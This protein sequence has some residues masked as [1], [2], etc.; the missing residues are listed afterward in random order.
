MA[1]AGQGGERRRQAT[2]PPRSIPELVAEAVNV[3]W[4]WDADLRTMP[5][6]VVMVLVSRGFG[7]E[8]S[9]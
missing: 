1:A 7:V 9:A 3:V 5:T 4:S 6:M 8:I 2:H